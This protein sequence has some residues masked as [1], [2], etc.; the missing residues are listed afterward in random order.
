MNGR[1]CKE[2]D[3][4]MKQS[5]WIGKEKSRRKTCRRKNG[6]WLMYFWHST[7]ESLQTYGSVIAIEQIMFKSYIDAT[8]GIF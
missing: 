5:W 6:W 8:T 1:K 2:E 4:G 3:K 7:D